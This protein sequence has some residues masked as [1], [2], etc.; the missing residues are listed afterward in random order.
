MTELKTLND[1]DFTD[2]AWSD[3]GSA[4]ACDDDIKKELKQEA[5]K[6][7]KERIEYCNYCRICIDR[8]T[9]NTIMITDYC[10]EHQ[11]W[12]ERFNITDKDLK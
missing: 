6:W 2:M 9:T 10:K 8:R 7:I 3:T 1:L 12:I 11:F 5:I 4:L